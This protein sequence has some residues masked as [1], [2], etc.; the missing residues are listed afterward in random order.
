MPFA[1]AIVD[2]ISGMLAQI[3]APSCTTSPYTL[4]YQALKKKKPVSLNNVLEK[5]V[6]KINIDHIIS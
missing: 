5:V 3:I 6:K 4:H 2:K 1:K